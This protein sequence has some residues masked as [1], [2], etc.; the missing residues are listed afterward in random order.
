MTEAAT[1]LETDRLPPGPSLLVTRGLLY[2]VVLLMA[3]AVTWAWVSSV[4]VVAIAE[5]RLT[6]RGGAIRLSAGQSGIL[7][8]VLVDIGSSVKAGETLLKVDPFRETADV[9]RLRHEFTASQTDSLRYQETARQLREVQTGTRDELDREAVVVR[10]RTEE[11]ERVQRLAGEGLASRQDAQAS[12]RSV[13][14]AGVRIARLRADILRA[15]EEITRNERLAEAAAARSRASEVEL[16]R[17]TESR[18]RTEI[19]APS[20]GVV[21]ELL[22]R[23][24]GRYIAA[25]EVA[26][27]IMPA[28]EPLYAEIRIPNESMRRVRPALPVRLKLK[29]YPYQDYGVIRGRLDEIDPDA[30]ESSAYRAW[31]RLEQS[32]LDGPRGAERLRPGLQLQAE[33]I[34]DRRRVIEILLDP[35]RRLRYGVSVGE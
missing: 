27:A 29:A 7:S 32:V 5:G 10:L 18:N 17:A 6:P 19:V 2:I 13:A 15:T 11:S 35:F 12:E 21:T 30:G 4:D 9:A 34:V 1:R 28:D 8:E 33:I 26:V 22:S 20:A 3:A 14:E 31:V 16:R 24:S 23:R 25:D